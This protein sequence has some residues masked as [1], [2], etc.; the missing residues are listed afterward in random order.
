MIALKNPKATK[1]SQNSTISLNAHAAK[2]VV[3]ILKD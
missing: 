3:G 1:C 2:V